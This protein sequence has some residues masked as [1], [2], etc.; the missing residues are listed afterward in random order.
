MK[1]NKALEG[2][3]IVEALKEEARRHPD[4]WLY[5]DAADLIDQLTAEPPNDPLTLDELRGMDGEPIYIQYIG[6]CEGF[7]DNETAPYYGQFEQY[8]QKYNGMLRACDLPLKY[9]GKTWLAYRR[10][11]DGGGE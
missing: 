7:Y 6:T 5:R 3:E 8:I 10:K 1:N 11:P 2:A 4:I 9:Y